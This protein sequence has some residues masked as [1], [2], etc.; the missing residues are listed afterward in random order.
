AVVVVDDPLP[1]PVPL[2]GAVVVLFAVVGRH[3]RFSCAGRGGPGEPSPGLSGHLPLRG[4]AWGLSSALSVAGWSVS[5]AGAGCVGAAVL[6]PRNC[7]SRASRASGGR[8]ASMAETFS[9]VGALPWTLA[10]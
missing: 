3:G 2:A 8:A 6:V 10:V 9:G 4:R 1:G 7:T 5:L